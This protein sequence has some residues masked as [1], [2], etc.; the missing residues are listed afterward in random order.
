MELKKAM[1]FTMDSLLAAGIIVLSIAL[2][3]NFY[4]S[5][6]QNTNINYASQDIVRVF[7][8]MKIG[9]V[10]NSYARELIA[11]GKITNLNKTLMEQIGDFWAEGEVGIAMNLSRNLTGDIV[12][13]NYGFSLVIDGE[14]IYT[15]NISL[16]KSLV[17]SR[18]IISG[19]TK[20][21]PTDSFSS[22]VILPSISSKTILSYA[23]FGGYVGDGTITQRL[24]LP[25]NYSNITQAYMEFA[26]TSDFDLQINGISSGSYANKEPD[27]IRAD[28][29][30]I[31]SS[32]YPN[33]RPGI[34]EIKIIFNNQSAFLGGGFF[35][36]S[37]NST[38]VSYLQF[39]YDAANNSITKTDY[40][41]GVDGVVN[42]YSSFYV[43]GDLKSAKMFLNYTTNYPVFVSF[44]NVTIY[45][46]NV[47]GDINI[48]LANSTIYNFFNDSYARLS[49][50][51]VPLRIGHFT[52]Q[53]LGDY[54]KNIDAFIDT[55]VDTSMDTQD[56]PDSPGVSRLGVAKT[57]EKGFVNFVL[58]KSLS[59][60]IGL[61]SYHSSVEPGQ[62]VDL[63][64]NNVTLANA[65]NGYSTKSVNTCFSCAIGDSK[66]R[67][68]AN[69]NTSKKWYIILMGDGVADKCDKIPQ[70]K[71]TPAAA[72]NESIQYACN[73]SMTYNISFYTIAIGA[74]ADN[75]TLKNISE[76]CSDGVFFHI[77]NKSQL[78]S[79]FS[80]IA[81]NILS[82]TFSLQKTVISGVNSALYPNSYLEL[83]YTPEVPPLVFGKIPIT[84]ET[85]AFGNN[86]TSGNISIAP[87]INV[88]EALVTSYSSDSWT[89]RTTINGNTAFNLSSYNVSYVE[90]GDP[91]LVNIP[92][93][94]V[95]SGNNTI[96]IRTSSGAGKNLSGGSKD[97]KA[98]YTILVENSVSFS[99][100]AT[101]AAGCKWNLTFEDGTSTIIKVP[102]NYAGN[103]MCDFASKSFDSD[104]S[105]DLA[106]YQ[107]FSNLDLDKDGKLD[108]NLNGNDLEISTLT[109]SKVPSLWGP[110]IIEIR[111]WE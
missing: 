69:G 37:L 44:G 70:S 85:E 66:D 48:T 24:K 105:I 95:Q 45:D 18:K 108:V 17:S 22:K 36:V 5:E 49:R 7:S 4:I 72:K 93:A 12:P 99:S 64:N 61:V 63:T 25:D 90:V 29:Y 75:T 101:K 79:A 96:D 111:V 77:D 106:A 58:N 10:D 80:E 65:I 74:G 89:E 110:S 35:K 78:Q 41:T 55:P 1:F 57:A 6:Q 107:L 86:V 19:I 88:I 33:F 83:Q 21:K 71:C 84:I 59:N 26:L 97:D 51:T 62:A 100:V 9:E 56:V 32:Y 38:D 2:V 50:K 68:V 104:D 103:A 52:T 81:D 40:L 27:T 98:I 14:E 3:S 47:T 20:A 31:S 53:K 30:N 42:I 43:P 87:N 15:H 13:K 34:N 94:L 11:T 16:Q 67:L 76:D 102:S 54:G 39:K 82:L 23:Y 8:S 92:V 28:K 109:I 46:K 91:F 73:A 60:R